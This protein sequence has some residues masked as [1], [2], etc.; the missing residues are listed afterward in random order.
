MEAPDALAQLTKMRGKES[1]VLESG[2]LEGRTTSRNHR[3]QTNKN[4]TNKKHFASLPTSQV[5][6]FEDVAAAFSSY[7]G[8]SKSANTPSIMPNFGAASSIPPPLAL[9]GGAASPTIIA[10]Q[11]GLGG[12]A[13]SSGVVPQFGLGGAAASSGVVP[14][15]VGTN[16]VPSIKDG[17]NGKKGVCGP[18]GPRRARPTHKR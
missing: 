7:A 4:T 2:L 15:I 9:L 8:A 1:E 3:P 5:L 12:A 14:P 6:W 18:D 16:A 13:S 11:F 10:P 17:T